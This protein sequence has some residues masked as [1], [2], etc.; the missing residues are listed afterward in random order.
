MLTY[1]NEGHIINDMLTCNKSQ[2]SSLSF[3][4]HDIFAILGTLGMPEHAWTQSVKVVVP[5]LNSGGIS[6]KTSILE[7]LQICYLETLGMTETF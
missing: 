4:K 6:P 3:L 2:Q 1:N 7:I 5:I